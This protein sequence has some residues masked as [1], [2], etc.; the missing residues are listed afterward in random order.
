VLAI[1]RRYRR[2]IDGAEV[3]APMH[4]AFLVRDF[5]PADGA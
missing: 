4:L 3:L 1:A 5:V 2:R